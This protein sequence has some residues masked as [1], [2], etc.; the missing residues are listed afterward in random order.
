MHEKITNTNRACLFSS[1][2]AGFSQLQDKL[3]QRFSING[4]A[5]HHFN[6]DAGEPPQK[7]QLLFKNERQIIGKK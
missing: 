6:F 5:T 4:K 3:R 1:S 7:W 2:R